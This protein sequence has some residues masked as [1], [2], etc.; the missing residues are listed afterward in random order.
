MLGETSPAPASGSTLFPGL[1]Q[2]LAQLALVLGR[3]VEA[4]RVGQLVEPGEAEEP[5][6][7]LRRLEDRGA[8][9][10]RPDSSI[11]PRSASVCTADSEETPRMRATSGRETGCR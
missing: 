9:R 1:E 8:E 2:P 6:E 5:L 7:Q 3:R 4:R 10:E 11:R